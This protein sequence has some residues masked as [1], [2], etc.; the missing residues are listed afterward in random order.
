MPLAVARPGIHSGAMSIWLRVTDGPGSGEEVELG[1]Q[2]VIGRDADVGLTLD[3]PGISRRHA[4]LRSEGSTAVLEDLDSSNG[5]YVNGERLETPR[6][7]RGGDLIQL[8]ASTIELDAGTTET[9]VISSP[10]TE[11]APPPSAPVREPP[12]SREPP[13]PVRREPPAPREPEPAPLQ[14]AEATGGGINWQ[15]IAAVVLGPLSILLLL[16]GSG[17]AFYAALPCGI[18]AIAL[19]SVGKRQAD[20]GAGMRGIAVA[21]QVAG[22]VGT[23]L[24]ALVILVLIAVSAATDIAADNLADLIDEVEAE[25]RNEVDSQTP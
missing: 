7:L 24:A 20:S 15:A 9:E 18:L 4:E 13:P 23:I 19:A 14:P 6:R 3:D 25:V 8:G 5:T 2:L 22:V 17:A 12:V 21:G 1:Q 16:V 10:P 11:V